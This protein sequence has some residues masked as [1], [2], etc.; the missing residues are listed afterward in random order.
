MVFST[1]LSTF[2]VIWVLGKTKFS[3]KV[4][5]KQKVLDGRSHFSS[6]KGFQLCRTLQHKTNDIIFLI[7]FF[8]CVSFLCVQKS[9]KQIQAPISRHGG[10]LD[11]YT[12]EF[13]G[14]LFA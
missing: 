12:P 10:N 11:L 13:L 8:L 5:R 1:I 2:C 9:S 4:T 6:M 7:S 14:R 3:K